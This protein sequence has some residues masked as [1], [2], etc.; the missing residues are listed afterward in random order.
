[1]LSHRIISTEGASEGQ[2]DRPS[3]IFLHGFL[4]S[5]QDFLPLATQLSGHNCL[6]IDL[7]G[8]GNSLG[9]PDFSY[10]M[11]GAAQAI[12]DILDHYQIPKNKI[13]G[14]SMGGRLA[15]YLIL[16]HPDRFTTA[17][18]ES[19]SPGLETSDQQLQRRQQ[20]EKTAQSLQTNFPKFLQ[21]WYQADLFKPLQHHSSFPE[22]LARRH[23]NNPT[24][25]TRSLFHMG[26]GTQP[27]L[28][29]ELPNLQ[30]P[31]HLIVGQNDPKFLTLN[32]KMHSLIRTSHLHPIPSATHNLHLETP[33]PI[34]TLLQTS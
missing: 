32:Q 23:N 26:T 5:H 28:W 27:N 16:R 15:L 19:A 6:L 17:Y 1:M 9:L 30:I 13:Y 10:T 34:L 25:L 18:L 24:E 31:I 22:L 21:T 29:P 20:D 2:T 33:T 3:L 12:L 14:Y 8:H 4:G 11:P 7:P